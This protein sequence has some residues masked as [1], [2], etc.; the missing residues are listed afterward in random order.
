MLS[1]ETV[2][3][4]HKGYD[5]RPRPHRSRA[6]RIVTTSLV[7]LS[8]L[9]VIS[10]A[11]VSFSPGIAANVADSVLRPTIGSTATVNLESF[12]FSVSD[13]F[14][15]ISYKFGAKPNADIFTQ[16]A[17]PVVSKPAVIVK[18]SKTVYTHSLD[19][20]PI[21]FHP[22]SFAKLPNEGQWSLLQLPQFGPSQDMARTFVTPDPK[23]SY[24]ITSV[25]KMNMYDLRLYAVAGTDQPGGPIGNAGAGFIPKADQLDGK[26]V[27]AFNGGFQYKD[28]RFG[29]VVGQKTY[30]PLQIGLGT[31]IIRKNGTVS[32]ETYSGNQSDIADA[33]AVRQNGYTIVENGQVT[34]V[35]AAGG[36][37]R[38]GLTVT[39]SMYT[40]RSGIGVTKDGDLLYAVGPSLNVDTLAAALQAAGAVT[41]IQLDIN[42]YW[43]RYV[44]Y[45]PKDAGTYTHQSLLKDMQDGGNSYLHG[46]NKD[47][48]YIKMK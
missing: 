38:W 37:A 8:A 35:T 10:L 16:P 5:K 9:L 40:W 39:N 28:G 48:F 20:S 6:R 36:M 17:S 21:N 29:M 11:V 4:L 45:Q 43:V 2:H 26:L 31:L 18:N 30:V 33:V 1:T 14:K 12:F 34:N 23:R 15:Q 13:F 27:A 41:A 42:P 44:T 19:L 25:V 24:A 47:F 22:G 3:S 32:I 7:S 46:Y